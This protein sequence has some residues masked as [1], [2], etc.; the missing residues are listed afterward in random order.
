MFKKLLQKFGLA[1]EPPR[2]PVAPITTKY[3]LMA[4]INAR[5]KLYVPAY[6]QGKF[7]PDCLN[8]IKS[9]ELK[10][11]VNL[12]Y[13]FCAN[14]TN[15]I[16]FIIGEIPYIAF[17]RC[18]VD[19]DKGVPKLVYQLAIPNNDVRQLKSTVKTMC[20]A[21]NAA[22]ELEIASVGSRLYAFVYIWEANNG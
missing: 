10:Y 6:Y 16:Y 13:Y 5:R 21:L 4:E 7:L 17:E 19:L 8:S 9:Y 18:V 22:S 3:T 15:A 20:N 12:D 14:A 2:L 11:G 1:K